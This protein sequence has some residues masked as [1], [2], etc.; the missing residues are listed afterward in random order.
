MSYPDWHDTYQSRLRTAAQAMELIQAND[1]VGLT[2]LS[3]GT[4]TQSLEA[5]AKERG[6]LNIP[7]LAPTAQ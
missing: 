1:L 3:P 6:Q 4:M 5:R 2:I 7:F